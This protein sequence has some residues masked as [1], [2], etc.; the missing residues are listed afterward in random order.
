[1]SD[2]VEQE[3]ARVVYGNH[4]YP[5]LLHSEARA[6]RD[7]QWLAS[8]GITELDSYEL[9]SS[10]VV[11]SWSIPKTE[12]WTSKQPKWK[13]MY[14]NVVHLPKGVK[15][16]RETVEYAKEAYKAFNDVTAVE[17]LAHSRS[18]ELGDYVTD[19]I[20]CGDMLSKTPMFLSTLLASLLGGNLSVTPR[21]L[22]L[23]LYLG[24]DLNMPVLSNGR[25]NWFP[26]RNSY[27]V[28]R[29]T[30]LTTPFMTLVSSVMY[31]N[32]RLYEMPK[33]PVECPVD[34]IPRH[35]LQRSGLN[36]VLDMLSM[37]AD[38]T[39]TILYLS[40]E[41]DA[42]PKRENVPACIG[43]LP[44]SERMGMLNIPIIL[45]GEAV[46]DTTKND[47]ALAGLH[48]CDGTSYDDWVSS[49]LFPRLFNALAEKD[50]KFIPACN[51]VSQDTHDDYHV[52]NYTPGALGTTLMHSGSPFLLRFAQ[53]KGLHARD[54]RWFHLREFAEAA[55]DGWHNDLTY[56]NE[57]ILRSRFTAG[58]SNGCVGGDTVY[59]TSGNMY[60]ILRAN[61]G[62]D[63][64]EG[65]KTVDWETLETVN[66]AFDLGYTSMRSHGS[67]CNGHDSSGS[68]QVNLL[69]AYGAEFPGC[70][71][72]SEP[73]LGR[74]TPFDF[75]M[76][77]YA[78]TGSSGGVASLALHNLGV[79]PEISRD[80]GTDVTKSSLL[81]YRV[82]C[83][84]T[85]S[86]SAPE[87]SRTLD[88]IERLLRDYG[89]DPNYKSGP[90]SQY[91]SSIDKMIIS[92]DRK[93]EGLDSNS[94]LMLSVK[95]LVKLLLQYGI[96]TGLFCHPD[97]RKKLNSY[98]GQYLPALADRVRKIRIAHGMSHPEDEPAAIDRLL[99]QER[100][101]E[102]K[103]KSKAKNK[104]S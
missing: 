23:M 29:H 81:M 78:A 46:S 10:A 64:C 20:Q 67:S 59:G 80:C 92:T 86:M 47:R 93:L 87:R 51:C 8:I 2:T 32:G 53:S 49:A 104:K 99:N 25:G 45:A 68:Y 52:V 88:Y 55:H 11:R 85:N 62:M 73:K 76:D 5:G 35:V 100:E 44:V 21:L 77:E 94:P 6:E 14:R 103:K 24:A 84:C 98:L 70:K 42:T 74:S 102:K 82:Q 50:S 57:S 63:F 41:Y 1:M 71:N 7:R 40:D 90:E 75:N 56:N 97:T 26:V 72:D 48:Q 31:D 3:E 16:F 101:S 37:G 12:A 27:K 83:Y 9:Y 28:D 19:L 36:L 22:S 60:V 43:E 79:M 30:I 69:W 34:S 91:H 17:K 65:C 96:R 33:S 15:V 66:P 95:R 18:T 39:F 54:L 61:K 38:P 89:A 4:N 13:D 58:L